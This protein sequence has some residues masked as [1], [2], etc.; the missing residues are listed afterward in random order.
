VDGVGDGNRVSADKSLPK[1]TAIE[2][3]ET[4]M[5]SRKRRSRRIL[6][7][8]SVFGTVVGCD[9]RRRWWWCGSGERWCVVVERSMRERRTEDI[10]A[11]EQADHSQ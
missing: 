6:Q 5:S 4:A 8:L 7:G 2:P 10:V 1:G 9:N 11:I 3:K